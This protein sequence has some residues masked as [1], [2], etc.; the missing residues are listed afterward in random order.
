MLTFRANVPTAAQNKGISP[1]E[2]TENFG[3]NFGAVEEKSG[4][5][6]GGN[7]GVFIDSRPFALIRDPLLPNLV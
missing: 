5:D 4:N 7:I 2:I 1:Q 3:E 6:A